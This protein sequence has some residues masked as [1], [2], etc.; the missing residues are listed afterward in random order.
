MAQAK[1][2]ATTWKFNDLMANDI[3]ILAKIFVKTQCFNNS[4]AWK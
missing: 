3:T 4:I 1:T 2:F